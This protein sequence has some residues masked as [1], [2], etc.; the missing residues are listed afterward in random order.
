MTGA[1]SEVYLSPLD[2]G[3]VAVYLIA[4]VVAGVLASRAASR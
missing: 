4:T 3:I 2:L 1:S